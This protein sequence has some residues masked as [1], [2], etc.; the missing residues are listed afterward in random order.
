MVIYGIYLY[1]I[2]SHA[3]E[4]LICCISTLGKRVKECAITLQEIPLYMMVY[5]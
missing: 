3:S 2:V 4:M 1:T 5:L